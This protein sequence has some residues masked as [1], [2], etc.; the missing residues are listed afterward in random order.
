MNEVLLTTVFEPRVLEH[1]NG[2]LL[3][4]ADVERRMLLMQ[5]QIGQNQEKYLAYA[6]AKAVELGVVKMDRLE[7]AFAMAREHVA[8]ES[9]AG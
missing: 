4:R 9:A 6:L 8:D 7:A 3:V 2:W 1:E 5:L